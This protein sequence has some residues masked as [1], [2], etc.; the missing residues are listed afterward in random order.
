MADEQKQHERKEASGMLSF[1]VVL[2]GS[3]LPHFTLLHA[4][5]I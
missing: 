1:R 2:V 3:A 5:G 4:L